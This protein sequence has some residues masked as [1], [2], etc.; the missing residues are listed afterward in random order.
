MNS[1]GLPLICE[2]RADL[3]EVAALVDAVEAWSEC[4]GVPR[5]AASAM[6][7]MLEEL[8]TNSIGHGH[9]GSIEVRLETDGA[10][11]VA[12]VSDTAPAF[13]PLAQPAADTAS[14]LEERA[15][16]GLGIHLVRRLAHGLDYRRVDGRNVMRVTRSF[17]G[18]GPAG[19]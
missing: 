12:C 10:A 15:V 6:T 9:A 5:A 3:T 16:G 7:L 2:L 18:G 17:G 8:V 13:D 1:P 4:H 19:N 14:A 11:L